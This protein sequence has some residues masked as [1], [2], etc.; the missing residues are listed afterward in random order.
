METVRRLINEPSARVAFFEKQKLNI[1]FYTVGFAFVLFVYHMLSDGDF[2]FLLTLG[3]IVRMFGF[4][5]LMVKFYVQK[6]ATG[7]SLKTLE[8][9]SL[10]FVARLCSILFYQG[11]L[12]YDS[13]GD[14]L[15]QTVEVISLLL[16]V[17]A[18]VYVLVYSDSYVAAEDAFGN[19]KYIP[20]QLGPIILVVPCF[21]LALLFH[22]TLNKNKLT[23]TAWTFAA[24]LETVAVLP[25]FYLLQK[26]NK[27]VESWVSHFVFSLGLSRL[28]LFIFWFSSFHELSDKKSKSFLSG[29][30]GYSILLVQLV[31]IAIMG[32]FCIYYLLA[33]K[34]QSPLVLDAAGIRV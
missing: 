22:P 16:C 17:A 12:P 1:I 10:V 24:Y 9:Y 3:G 33:A 13:S 7:I 4:G 14:W 11:Y 20:S 26:A 2:S 31:H 25:Q 27:A 5:I 15:Y 19:F 28:F 6:S 32:E 30:S 23:D 21:I 18:I 34:R 8:L 29:F